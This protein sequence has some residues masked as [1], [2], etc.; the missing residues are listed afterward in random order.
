MGKPIDKKK[1]I[2]LMAL[3]ANESTEDAFKL[4]KKYKKPDG[5]NY[6]A[7]G[8]KELEE[9][10]AQLYFNSND[11]KIEIEKEFAK[12]HPHKKW[13]LKYEKPE[14]VVEVVAIKQEVLPPPPAHCSCEDCKAMR[15]A[16][17]GFSN[18]EG[19]AKNAPNENV[20]F[21][22]SKV[23]AQTLMVTVGVIGVVAI[24]GLILNRKKC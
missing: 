21:F 1:D 22:G 13:L 20:G 9:Q 16:V 3:L 4:L 15:I 2:T 10:L 23:N 17:Q 6:I 7:R 18:A 14:K 5:S 8:Y 11:S 19:E 12:I 24:V